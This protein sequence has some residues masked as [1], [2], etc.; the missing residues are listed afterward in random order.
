MED[1]KVVITSSSPSQPVL[2]RGLTRRTNS[3][4]HSENSE[5][6]IM[7]DE[8]TSPVIA[9]EVPLVN[10]NV[11]KVVVLPPNLKRSVYHVDVEED[12]RLW[13][14]MADWTL[15]GHDEVPEW[16]RGNPF[17]VGGYRVKPTWNMILRSLFRNHNETCNIWTHLFGYLSF[18]GL[19][20]MTYFYF[21]E[22]SHLY[23]KLIF[24]LFLFFAQAQ[25]LFSAIFHLVACKSATVYKWSVRLDYSGI[26]FMIVGSYCPIM[27]YAFACNNAARTVY[28]T[29]ICVL[30]FI[31]LVLAWIPVFSTPRC[32]F[33]RT[34]YYIGF[35][36]SSV[37]PFIHM[38]FE[39]GFQF[40]F[41][42]GWREAIMGALYIGGSFIYM[43]KV[44]ERWYPGRYD[45]S[46]WSSHSIWHLFVLAAAYQQLYAVLWVYNWRRNNLCEEF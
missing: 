33:I 16:M 22:G 40:A 39:A 6:S 28:I 34:S 4:G 45:Y 42:L 24:G 10:G 43:S 46:I 23:D 1:I 8:L 11:D 12:D 3:K 27:Y 36:L 41:S 13:P 17:I 19:T 7:L 44:P 26:S 29:G 20:V 35:G 38:L 14:P 5:D 31:G 15:R 9:V 2:H 32:L 21:L 25:M 18:V 37:L 30:G